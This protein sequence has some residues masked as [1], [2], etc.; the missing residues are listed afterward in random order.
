MLHGNQR[1][2]IDIICPN[3]SLAGTTEFAIIARGYTVIITDKD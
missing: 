3:V 1:N 2:T